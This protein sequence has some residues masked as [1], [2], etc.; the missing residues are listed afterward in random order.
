MTQLESINF[1]QHTHTSWLSK[2]VQG[3]PQGSI[4]GPPLFHLYINNLPSNIHGVILVL[5]AE[6]TSILVARKNE[7]GVQQKW[8]CCPLKMRM[9]FNKNDDVVQLK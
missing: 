3:M 7:D 4:L 6:E 5:F 1:T 2:T 9:L 8:R